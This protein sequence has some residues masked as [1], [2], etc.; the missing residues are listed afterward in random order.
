MRRKFLTFLAL[1]ILLT[2]TV[3]ILFKTIEDRSVAGV[4]AGSLFLSFGFF[5]IYSLIKTKRYIKAFSFYG[6]IVHLA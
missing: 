2:I 6:A 1:E 3:I 4:I 5:I